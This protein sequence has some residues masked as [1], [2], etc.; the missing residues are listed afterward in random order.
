MAE[1]IPTDADVTAAFTS[2]VTAAEVYLKDKSEKNA[3]ELS[4]KAFTYGMLLYIIAQF[5][6]K[7][8]YKE[9]KEL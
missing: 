8:P 2:L 7:E 5:Q 3:E 9:N 6:L 1:E 4:G